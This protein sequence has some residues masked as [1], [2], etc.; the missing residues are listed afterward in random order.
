M[1]EIDTVTM[2]EQEGAHRQTN[3]GSRAP[4]ASSPAESNTA[5][6]RFDA[7]YRGR[8]NFIRYGFFCLAAFIGTAVRANQ[9]DDLELLDV[10]IYVPRWPIAQNGY[11][12]AQ[13]SD[14][15]CDDDRCV[16]RVVHGVKL[17]MQQKPDVAVVTG[18]FVS[19]GGL[20]FL[21]QGVQALSP[22][23]DLPGGAYA[24]LGNHDWYGRSDE[25]VAS[26]VAASGITMLRNQSTG[27]PGVRNAYFVGLD[28]VTA[29]AHDLSKA[30]Q[31]VPADAVRILLVHEPDFADSAGPGFALQ[32]S[33][34]SHGGQ[35]RIPSLP[36][37]HTPP[38]GQRYPQGLQQCATHPVYTSKGVGVTGVDLRLACRPDVT[39]IR[40][41]NAPSV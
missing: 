12:I 24:I 16:A 11:T 10:S 37:L 3:A 23:R 5:D 20:D 34:H 26:A 4:S 38:L 22:L 41:F 19:G 21:H 32:L 31:G 27:I 8:R 6:P 29:G 25:S 39:L 7:R 33:G 28:D 36:P 35:I 1:T 2:H 18:D 9:I 15:H 13:I 40:I 30:L 14:L 17:L